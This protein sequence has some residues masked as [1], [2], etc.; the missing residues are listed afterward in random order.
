MVTNKREF[1]CGAENLRRECEHSQVSI[2]KPAVLDIPLAS[3]SY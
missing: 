2:D 1:H 3:G